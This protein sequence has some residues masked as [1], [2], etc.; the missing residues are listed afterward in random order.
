MLLT[1]AAGLVGWIGGGLVNWAA[2]LLPGINTQD[3][4]PVTLPHWQHHWAPLRSTSSRRPLLVISL[5]IVL[6]VS[7]TWHWGWSAQLIVGWLYGFF[8]L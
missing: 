7:M 1:L 5:S 6:A 3:G 8:L 4:T 2:D